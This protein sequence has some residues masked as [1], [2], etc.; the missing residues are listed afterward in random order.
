M[1]DL[2][3]V[4]PTW[5][6]PI[7]IDEYAIEITEAEDMKKEYYL[8]SNSPNRQFNLH[9]IGLSDAEYAILLGQYRGVTGEYAAF[10]WYTVPSYID[11]GSGSGVSMHGR[12]VSQPKFKPNARSWNVEIIFEKDES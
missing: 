9:F 1:A 8:L 2:T 11:G 4:T 12:W 3:T 10:D 7:G 6:T 5:V